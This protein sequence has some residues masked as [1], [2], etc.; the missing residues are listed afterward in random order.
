LKLFLLIYNSQ[1]FLTLAIFFVF[2]P[3]SLPQLGILKVFPRRLLLTGK[4]FVFTGH[5]PSVRYNLR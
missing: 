1:G 4:G 3:S 2:P 5:L